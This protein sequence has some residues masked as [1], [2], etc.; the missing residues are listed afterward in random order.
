MLKF[1]SVRDLFAVI[2]FSPN[3]VVCCLIILHIFTFFMA[4][5]IFVK[6]KL[7]RQLLWA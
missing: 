3:R 6:E 1:P 2:L 4:I 7:V 5:G